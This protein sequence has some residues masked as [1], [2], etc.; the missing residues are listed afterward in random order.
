M[1]LNLG[2]RRKSILTGSEQNIKT[3]KEIGE[4]DGKKIERTIKTEIQMI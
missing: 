1:Q 3:E 2:V 4:S